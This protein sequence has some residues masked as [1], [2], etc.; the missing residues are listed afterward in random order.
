MKTFLNIYHFHAF[1]SYSFQRHKIL[2]LISINF[3]NVPRR[4]KFMNHI[5]QVTAL[6]K[7]LLYERSRTAPSTTSSLQNTSGGLLLNLKQN[8]NSLR[9][10]QNEI[11]STKMNGFL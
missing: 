8:D 3:V 7:K 10:P 11:V 9:V 1:T 2:L 4:F 5:M 6:R